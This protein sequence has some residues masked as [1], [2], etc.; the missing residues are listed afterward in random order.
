LGIVSLVLFVIGCFCYGVSAI[1]TLILG[2]IGLI[3]ANKGLSVYKQN[4]QEYSHSSLSSVKNGRILNIV[5]VILSGLVLLLYLILMIFFG[6]FFNEYWDEISEEFGNI[7]REY[8][9]EMEEME[10]AKTYET[11]EDDWKYEE[12]IDTTKTIKSNDSLN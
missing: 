7:E 2:I 9:Q 12:D 3:S 5:S 10:D 11:T 4:P 6:A 8:E 1:I